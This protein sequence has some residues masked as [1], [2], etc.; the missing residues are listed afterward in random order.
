MDNNKKEYKTPVLTVHGNVEEITLA[1]SF[2]NSD[3]A[4]GTAGTAFPVIT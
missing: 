2:P 4:A 1:S 3:V